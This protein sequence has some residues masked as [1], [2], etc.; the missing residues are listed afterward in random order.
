M[1]KND[2]R[3]RK[4]VGD[5]LQR[6]GMLL[7][8]QRCRYANSLPQAE[9][10][11]HNDWRAIICG[12]YPET[13]QGRVELERDSSRHLVDRCRPTQKEALAAVLTQ[14]GWSYEALTYAAGLHDLN[15]QNHGTCGDRIC[16]VCTNQLTGNTG[17]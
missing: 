4:Q 7:I 16:P 1:N 6:C 8:V 15:I 13:M 12:T 11:R 10:H 5:A 9:K 2:I 14:L 3:S 17:R